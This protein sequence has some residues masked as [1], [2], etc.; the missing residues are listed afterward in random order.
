MITE[1]EWAGGT[2]SSQ[3]LTPRFLCGTMG[4]R[5]WYR[6]PCGSLNQAHVQNRLETR[7]N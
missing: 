3:G 6:V 5:G 7:A 4:S 1:C 2:D